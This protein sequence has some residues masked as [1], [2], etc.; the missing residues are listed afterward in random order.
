MTRSGSAAPFQGTW[1]SVSQPHDFDSVQTEFN[2]RFL[3]LI[4]RS[5]LLTATGTLSLV[6]TA[7]HASQS[8]INL[9]TPTL[10]AKSWLLGYALV[11]LAILLGLLAVLIP[12]MRKVLRR[13]D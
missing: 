4:R 6:T 10:L 5:A 7:A 1:L 3:R 2:M 12:S 9:A 11:F 13:K 8:S